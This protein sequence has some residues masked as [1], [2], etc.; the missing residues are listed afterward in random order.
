MGHAYFRKTFRQCIMLG[1]EWYHR[2]KKR[3]Y[4]ST[5]HLLAYQGAVSELVVARLERENTT[6]CSF[7]RQPGVRIHML[8]HLLTLFLNCELC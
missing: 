8:Y 5:Y 3:A 4:D 2:P 6:T 7:S 1:I